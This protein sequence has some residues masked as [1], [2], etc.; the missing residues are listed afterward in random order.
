[1]NLNGTAKTFGLI[2]LQVSLTFSQNFEWDLELEQKLNENN[3]LL[4][5][6]VD[7]INTTLINP[8]KPWDVLSLDDIANDDINSPNNDNKQNPYP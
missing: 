1:M 2:A 3:S 7:F 4:S 8:E 6:S 5:Q